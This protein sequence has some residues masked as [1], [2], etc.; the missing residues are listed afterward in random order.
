MFSKEFTLWTGDDMEN[1][2]S[3]VYKLILGIFLSILILPLFILLVWSFA[4]NWP[5]PSLLP[6][7]WGLRGWAYFLNPSGD[8]IS[9][10]FFSIF[11]SSVVALVSLAVSVPAAKALALYRFRGRKLMEMLVFAPAIVPTMTVAMG[12]HLQFIKLGLANTFAGVVL[13]QLIP[14]IPYC[15][16]ILKSVFEIVGEEMELQARMLG[17]GS[18]QIFCCVTL[19]MI[20]PGIISA[21]SMAFIVSFSQ[22]FLTFLIGGGRIVTFSMLMFPYIESGDR[23]LGAVYSLVFIF[24][25][26]IFLIIMEKMT[27]RFYNNK[28]KE[29]TYV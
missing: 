11:L 22:Y 10:L 19:P 14:C 5:W 16:T 25:T 2:S 20:L 1:K 8:S 9:V 23:M 3:L 17:A 18:Y 24:T 28:L 21:G 26:L 7:S 15:I 27:Y 6:K 13:I 12:M 29:Y 4:K